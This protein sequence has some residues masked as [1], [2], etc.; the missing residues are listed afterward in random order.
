MVAFRART[1]NRARKILI[2]PRH[3]C[4]HMPPGAK[5]IFLEPQH[6]PSLQATYFEIARQRNAQADF[7]SL[8]RIKIKVFSLF[9]SF[10]PSRTLTLTPTDLF[11]NNFLEARACTGPI[12]THT[13]RVWQ[14]LSEFLWLHL[15]HEPKTCQKIT[16]S[17]SACLWS[18]AAGC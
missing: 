7:W 8:K 18:Y 5:A 10:S 14:T 1:Q 6:L 9:F 16:S 15:A 12:L 3:I 17:F 13:A 11:Q 2:R 4:C